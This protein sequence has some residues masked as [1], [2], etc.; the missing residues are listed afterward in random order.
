MRWFTGAV[1]PSGRNL[2]I[3]EL[4]SGQYIYL[5]AGNLVYMVCKSGENLQKYVAGQKQVK[6]GSKKQV[7]ILQNRVTGQLL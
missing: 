7:K 1:G 5:R 4:N 2:R 6:I 3:R